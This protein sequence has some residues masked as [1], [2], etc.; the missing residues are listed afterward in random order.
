MTMKSVLDLLAHL[1]PSASKLDTTSP[2]PVPS[3]PK[4]DPKPAKD[5]SRSPTVG[6]LSPRHELVPKSSP[7]DLFPQIDYL[8]CWIDTSFDEASE[9]SKIA[10]TLKKDNPKLAVFP[11][12]TVTA[13]NEWFDLDGYKV[14]K[15]IRIVLASRKDEHIEKLAEKAMESLSADPRKSLLSIF[16]YLSTSS[17]SHLASL[18]SRGIA[19]THDLPE[20]KRFIATSSLHASA[21]E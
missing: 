13:F 21:K 7:T 3:P 19:A 14:A 12:K 6:V 1:R 17:S 20:L 11:F 10:M 5:R 4:E 15:R 2:L 9:S 18:K 8:V 16:V